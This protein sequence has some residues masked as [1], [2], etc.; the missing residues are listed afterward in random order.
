M[1]C[2]ECIHEELCMDRLSK[3]GYTMYAN[4]ELNVE[5]CEHYRSK[6]DFVEV[7][8]LDCVYS[9]PDGT[10]CR[11]NVGRAVEPEHYCSYGERRIQNDI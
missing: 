9:N 4:R 10:I 11:Y 3:Q 8:C 6:A 2:Y 5:D 1:T 7:R